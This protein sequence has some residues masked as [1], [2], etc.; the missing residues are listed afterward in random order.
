MLPLTVVIP[1]RDRSAL[2]R[3]ALESVARQSTLPEAVVV[4]DDGSKEDLARIA[5]EFGAVY[6]R[7]PHG[8]PSAARNAGLAAAKT[9]WVAFLDCDDLWEPEKLARQWEALE[10]HPGAVLAFCDYSTFTADGRVPSRSIFHDD[11]SDVGNHIRDIRDAYARAKTRELPGDV[12]LCE[13]DALLNG[14]ARYNFVLTSTL[15]VRR[16]DA[17][18]AGGFDPNL[19]IA[20]DWEFLL[21][22]LGSGESFPMAVAIDRPLVRYRVHDGNISS[23]FVPAAVGVTGM[24]KKIQAEASRYPAPAVA[25]WRRRLGPYATSAGVSAVRSGDF[26]AARI[27]LDC[28]LRDRLSLLGVGAFAFSLLLDNDLGHGVVHALR[29]LRDL[30]ASHTA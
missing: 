26:H 20:E 18:A 29:S 23:R 10:Q 16:A 24:A 7:I 13:G 22:L 30:I 9:A 11:G 17:L 6:V 2:L 28:G 27:L 19:R 8:G 3:E 1:A 15:L 5:R 4:V 21:R 14:F 12:V 25:Y